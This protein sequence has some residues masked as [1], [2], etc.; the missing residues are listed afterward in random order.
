MLCYTEHHM[1]PCRPQRIVETR[2]PRARATLLALALLGL[3][4]PRPAADAAKGDEEIIA[5]SSRAWRGYV[6]AKLP[7][8]TLAPET[9]VFAKGGH[10]SGAMADNTIDKLDFLDIA[11]IVAKPLADRKYVP[12]FD[13]EKTN[14]MIMVYWGTTMG[15]NDPGM[16]ATYNVAQSTQ[17]VVPPPPPPPPNR[18]TAPANNGPGSNTQ[19]ID[20]MSLELMMMANRQRDSA[21]MKNAMLLGYDSELAET[22]GLEN[23]ALRGARESLINDL[24]DDRYFVILMAY[25]FQVLWKEKKH[26]LLWETRISLRQ[27]GNDFGKRLPEMML[28]AS[29]YFGSDTDGLVRNRIPEGR[30]EVGEPKVIE[31]PPEK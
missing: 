16:Q 25:D 14:L 9:Y 22:T 23:T 15:A 10:V 18:G 3:L 8:G 31:N 30:V 5:V 11:R 28:N 20:S 4:L 27:R 19:T 24:E 21:D 6:R 29:R 1:Y 7:D 17:A 13:P 26:R 2:L 12:A